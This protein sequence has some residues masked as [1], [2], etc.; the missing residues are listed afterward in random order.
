MADSSDSRVINK[1]AVPVKTVRVHSIVNRLFAVEQCLLALPMQGFTTTDG[2]NV[3][4]TVVD[5]CIDLE[6]IRRD[7]NA[8]VSG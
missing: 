3:G 4:R 7:L 6:A 1:L 2:K 5:A 8:E